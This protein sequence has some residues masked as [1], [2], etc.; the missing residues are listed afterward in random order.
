MPGNRDPY[1][2]LTIIPYIAVH[3]DFQGV[4]IFGNESYADWILDHLIGEVQKDQVERSYLGL[5]VHPDNQRAIRFYR[6]AGF[7]SLATRYKQYIRMILAL[8]SATG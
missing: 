5:C 6:K 3:S 2:P 1:R 8:A 7:A 4:E